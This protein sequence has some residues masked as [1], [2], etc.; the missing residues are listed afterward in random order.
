MW[1]AMAFLRDLVDVLF[2]LSVDFGGIRLDRH[3]LYCRVR[4]RALLVGLVP[5]APFPARD[6]VLDLDER[7]D[8]CR[9]R[10]RVLSLAGFA[11]ESEFLDSI[12]ALA[13][14]VRYFRESG[15]GEERWPEF[16]P[17][18]DSWLPLFVRDEVAVDEVMA[19]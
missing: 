17:S 16:V 6:L 7:E 5:L 9:A 15:V 3:L 4:R 8:Y 19:S 13:R 14:L 10:L 2:S 18:D 11:A 12:L 1:R